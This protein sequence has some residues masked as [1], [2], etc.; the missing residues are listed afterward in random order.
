MNINNLVTTLLVG[1]IASIAFIWIQPLFG[2]LTLTSRHAAAYVDIGGYSEAIAVTLSWIV[3]VSVSI[4]YT[5]VS[6]LIY[7]LNHSYLVNFLQV[8]LL[9]WL[10]TLLAT[11]ANEWVVKLITTGQ[12]PAIDSLSALNTQVGPKLW[13]H[14]LF[15]IMVV[16]GISIIRNSSLL[17]SAQARKT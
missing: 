12:L 11:P 13:L 8:V 17:N 14:M 2:M 7:N 15:F 3:H 9:G 6:L 10:T 4:F 5:L 1:V 16:V